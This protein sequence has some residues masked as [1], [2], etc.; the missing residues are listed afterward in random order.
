MSA[1][2]DNHLLTLLVALPLVGSLFV[3]FVPAGER[4]L[5]RWGLA[6]AL[7]TL[8]V[9]LH[10][11]WWFDST[12]SGFQYAVEHPWFALPGTEATVSLALGMDGL[13]VLLVALSGIL[14]P[15]VLVAAP[16]GIK[17]RIREFVFWALMMEAG[18]MGVF[19]AQDLVLFYIFWEVS[20]I[21]LY[22]LIG[23]WGGE[24]RIYA[25]VKFVL[26]TLVGSLLML[27]GLIRVALESGTTNIPELLSRD[28]SVELQGFAFVCFA[29]SFL[30]KV[31]V[32]PF[33]TWL[34]DAHVQAPT[35][36][37]V[38]LAGVMLK[39]GTYGLMRFGLQMFPAAAV[40]WAP[41]LIVI[42]VV[43]ILYGSLLAWAQ[44][45]L[46]KLVAYSSV[47][48]L[49]FVVLGIFAFEPT[50]LQGAVLQGVNHGISTGALFFLVG[51][52]YDRRHT[53]QLKDFGG[54]ATSFP[55]FAFFLVL[56]TLAS[57]GLPGTN[58]FVGEF[59][60]LFGSFP[61]HEWAVAF[62][63][64]GV[65]LGAVYMLG[66]CREVLFGRVRKVNRD[67]K[68]MQIREWVAL[69]PLA[70]LMLWIGLYPGPV[71]D[72]T[73]LV[74]EA[75]SAR[76]QPYLEQTEEA[77]LPEDSESSA[78]TKSNLLNPQ[79]MER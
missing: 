22:F 6:F 58:G 20:L 60:I 40:D 71:L 66:M 25:T 51:V 37:S 27:V 49:G 26:Y 13:S 75:M 78:D 76:V 35:G 3:L 29:L 24:N 15:L 21:P 17:T 65:V 1:F 68:P 44:R 14:M 42:G 72:R 59:L 73:R 77:S 70:A 12:T 63:A 53:R 18:M 33:H 48:H 30:I 32:V 74:C 55:S 50:A 10:G 39:M 16:G 79:G 2:L 52:I 9:A 23:I 7:A 61:G 64:L 67:L 38:I 46:K 19:L 8:A 47:A 4:W 28:L 57:V 43:G 36:G 41:V 54:L 5:R 11:Y 31:P 69:T 62:A 45:D 34:P 56:A